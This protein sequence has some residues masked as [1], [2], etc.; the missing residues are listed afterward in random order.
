MTNQEIL[1]NAPEGATHVDEDGVYLNTENDSYWRE[2]RLKWVYLTE[3]ILDRNTRS[4]VDIARIAEFEELINNQIFPSMGDGFSGNY[5]SGYEKAL[6]DMCKALK[7]Q[8]E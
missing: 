3:L 8:G 6:A 5:I 4:L 2:T 7:E 1:E